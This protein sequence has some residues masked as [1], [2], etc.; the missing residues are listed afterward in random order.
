MSSND[1]LWCIRTHKHIRTMRSVATHTGPGRDNWPKVQETER[2]RLEQRRLRN[3]QALF[4]AIR[5]A[6]KRWSEKSKE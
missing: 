5:I 4:L 1:T 2:L 6:S 3:R